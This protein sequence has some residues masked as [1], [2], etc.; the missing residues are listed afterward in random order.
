MNA[1][2]VA[3]QPSREVDVSLV[4]PMLNESRNVPTLFARLEP[5]MDA[6]GLA[7]EAV[8]VDDGSSDG[9]V[10]ALRAVQARRHEVVI[11]SFARNFGQHAA[12][13]AG[14][15]HARGRW[16]VTL[17]ADLQ[18][19][20]EEVPRVVERLR[21]GHDLVHTIRRD[22]QDNA[23][24]RY[25]SRLSTRI[26]RRMTRLRISDFGCMLRGYGRDV[27]QAIVR[28]REHRTFIPA[29]GA[30]FASSP[31]EIEVEHEARA[32]GTSN[33]SL[34]RLLA[35]HLDLVTSFSVQPLR[36][37]FGLGMVLAAL[38]VG[39]GVLLLVL[40]ILLGPDWANHGT[41]TVL[42]VVLILSGGQFIAFGLLGEYLGRIFM[43][44]RLREP[45][46]VRAIERAG[47]AP[48]TPPPVTADPVTTRYGA[49]AA[50]QR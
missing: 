5:A 13:A 48:M 33:Y 38:G 45:Y 43:Q 2:P 16:I 12:V 10:A 9:T 24:R 22:R 20:P 50:G 46:L 39:C 28:S 19:P 27:A 30:V 32:A 36:L 37:L 21:A 8:C 25:A 29:L 31:T 47:E 40:R 4:I 14:F 44:V 26:V 41:L 35:L 49:S 15:A 7:W 34:T 11:V 23:F 42:G 6:M 1:E 18:N 17:D 3:H